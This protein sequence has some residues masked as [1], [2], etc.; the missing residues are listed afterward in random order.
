MSLHPASLVSPTEHSTKVLQLLDLR[1]AR[2]LIGMYAPQKIYPSS[3]DLHLTEHVV[4]STAEV[5][6]FAL[7]APTTS[8]SRGRTVSRTSKYS[9]FTQFVSDVIARAEVT[10]SD[11]L[12]TL[13]YIQRARPYLSVQTEEWALH[14]VFLG[15]LI[16]A[17]KYTNDSTLKNIHWAMVTNTFGK[18]D[19]GRIEREFIEVLD[20]DLSVS[21]TDLLAVR[22]ALLHLLP[23]QHTATTAVRSEFVGVSIPSSPVTSESDSSE[24]SHWSDEDSDSDSHSTPATSPGPLTPSHTASSPARSHSTKT[25]GSVLDALRH[26]FWHAPHHPLSLQVVA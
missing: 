19:I 14:R 1:I 9:E 4:Q 23:A 6:N 12:V 20:W 2:G 3:T 26:P 18:R 24:S 25:V 22:D 10:V 7:G 21:E 15:A 16:V 8:T 13:V 5:I 11:L 17:S